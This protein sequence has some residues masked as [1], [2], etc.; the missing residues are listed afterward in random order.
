MYF[1]SFPDHSRADFDERLHF[2]RFGKANIIF[3]AQSS[4]AGCNDHVGCLSIKTVLNGEEWYG[5][6]GRKVAVRPGQFLV[7]NNGQSYSCRIAGGTVRSAS[8]FFAHDFAKAVLRDSLQSEQDLIDNP[9]HDGDSAPEF[10]QRLHG[11]EGNISQNLLGLIHSLQENGYDSDRVDEQLSALLGD[12]IRIHRNDVAA[13][14]NLHALKSSTQKEIFKRV[15]IARD[16]IQTA[17]REEVSLKLLGRSRVCRLHNSFASS[18]QR[19]A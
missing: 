6:N 14:K 16:M 3:N 10:Y 12:L 18:R 11:F 5:I 9:F 15:C 1:T 7:L 8:V 2:S 19:S 17:Y 4:N 13:S